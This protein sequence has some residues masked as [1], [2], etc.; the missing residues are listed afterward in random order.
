MTRTTNARVAGLAFL[1][2]IA[3]SLTG[4]I[5]SGRASGG[6]GVA[7]KLANIA[8]HASQMRAAI[9]L[10]LVGCVCALVLAVTLWSITR[11]QDPDLAMLV[12]TCRTAEGVI[13]AMALPRMAGCLWL[14]TIAG[15]EA[16]D[17]AAAK[18]IGNDLFELP[19]WSTNVSATFFAIGS[20]VFA[21]L[22]LRGRIVPAGLSQV[23]L[24]A[25]IVVVVG[26]P[27]ELVG[28]LPGTLAQLM[29]LPMLAFEVPLGIWLIV[30]GAAAPRAPS[31]ARSA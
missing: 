31:A 17:A 19:R 16:P 26:L 29:W 27:L 21:W 25:S 28:V 4:G 13:S 18:A 7:A 30:K 5:L 1:L 11:D 23:G 10:T 20:L 22:L 6:D 9:L 12:L 8:G 15:P 2:Y 24:F 14:A 3:A